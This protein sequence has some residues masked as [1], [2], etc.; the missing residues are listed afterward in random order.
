MN[1]EPMEVF[2]KGQAKNVTE[3]LFWR[4]VQCFKLRGS[5]E[6]QTAGRRERNAGSQNGEGGAFEM[7]GS[8][9]EMQLQCQGLGGGR[10]EWNS[11][12]C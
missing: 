6:V 12:P 7:P 4:R 10:K 11:L 9:E 8:R 3:L 1:V 5:K 2:D